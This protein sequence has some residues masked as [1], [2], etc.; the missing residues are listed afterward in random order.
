M[1]RIRTGSLLSVIRFADA[2]FSVEDFQCLWRTRSAMAAYRG[3][4][5][6]SEPVR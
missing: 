6:R 1:D 5:I 3:I 2:D 4:Y